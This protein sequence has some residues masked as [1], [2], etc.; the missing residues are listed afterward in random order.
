MSLITIFYLHRHNQEQK[1]TANQTFV[2]LE[3]R[4]IY[5]SGLIVEEIYFTWEEVLPVKLVNEEM[6]FSL[7][8]FI[9]SGFISLAKETD[10]YLF[11]FNSILNVY[12]VVFGFCLFRRES[13]PF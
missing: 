2:E 11:L 7:S 6:N 1:K 13:D 5:F 12:S 8:I 10:Q 3:K 4:D 9:Y